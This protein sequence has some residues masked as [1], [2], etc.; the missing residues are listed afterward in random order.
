MPLDFSSWHDFACIVHSLI[1]DILYT[2]ICHLKTVGD[3][4]SL[5]MGGDF[6]GM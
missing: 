1:S 4:M 6:F 5:T 2:A 3:L